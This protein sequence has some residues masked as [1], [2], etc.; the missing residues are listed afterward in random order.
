MKKL[1]R[2]IVMSPIEVP[3]YLIFKIAKLFL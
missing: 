3:V 1:I 2:G